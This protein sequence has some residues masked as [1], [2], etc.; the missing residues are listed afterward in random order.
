MVC[1]VPDSA[2]TLTILEYLALVRLLADM[3]MHL[4][5]NLVLMLLS[6][7]QMHLPTNSLLLPCKQL[8]TVDKSVALQATTINTEHH[9]QMNSLLLRKQL[10]AVE[11]RVAMRDNFGMAVDKELH[12]RLNSSLL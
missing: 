9:C 3:Q 5:T 6:Y 4:P 11:R 7:M 12:Q 2:P 1:I 10:Q 8:Q